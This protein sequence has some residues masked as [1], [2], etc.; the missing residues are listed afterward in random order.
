MCDLL[1]VVFDKTSR[2]LRFGDY[3]EEGDGASVGADSDGDSGSGW[4]DSDGE[5]SYIDVSY[6]SRHPR[7]L[8]T[9]R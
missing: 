7:I 4:E 9:S 6:T 2:R 1:G 8:L 5:G 3:V